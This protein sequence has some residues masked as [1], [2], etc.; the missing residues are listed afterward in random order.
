M[1]KL[2]TKI[3]KFNKLKWYEKIYFLNNVFSIWKTKI[4]YGKSLLFLGKRS[5]IQKPLMITPKYISIGN[6]VSI[7]YNCRIQG[8][9]DIIIN[10][11][12][13]KLYL[14]IM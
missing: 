11:F 5:K 7:F 2:L 8:S 13:R 14:T 3:S 12:H 9:A 4:I 6:D 10:Y 1:K